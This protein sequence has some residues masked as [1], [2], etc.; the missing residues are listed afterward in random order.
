[1]KNILITGVTGFVGSHMADYILKNTDD[2]IYA[3]KRWME[4]TKNVD[5][6]DDER[7]ARESIPKGSVL[8]FLKE[9]V[10]K[11]IVDETKIDSFSLNENYSSD[12]VRLLTKDEL[13]DILLKEGVL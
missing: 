1:M 11:G 2:T 4:D 12:K 6:I 13:K 10:N 7:F 3:T 9:L 8:S 5:H